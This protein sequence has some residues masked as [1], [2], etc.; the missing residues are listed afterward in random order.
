M[1]HIWGTSDSACSE[2]LVVSCLCGWVLCKIS[3]PELGREQ[4]WILVWWEELAGCVGMEADSLC[5][6]LLACHNKETQTRGLNEHIFIS[7]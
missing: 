1:F 3:F 6:S 7:S 2:H 5:I 4:L